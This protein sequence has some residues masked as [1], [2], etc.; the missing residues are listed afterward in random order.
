[1]AR[2]RARIAAFLLALGVLAG[3]TITW[4][5]LGGAPAQ[6]ATPLAAQARADLCTTPEWQADF[7]ACVKKLSDVTSDRAQCL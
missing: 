6:A 3:A 7:R 2:V 1:M 5:V 4:P